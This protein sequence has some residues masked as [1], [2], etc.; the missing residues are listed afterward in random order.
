MK[1]LL[2]DLLS[3]KVKK[4]KRR[5]SSFGD[6]EEDNDGRLILYLL[7]N[8]DKD[9]FDVKYDRKAA[10]ETRKENMQAERSELKQILNEEFGWFKKDS[11][12]N[13][14]TAIKQDQEK[15][16]VEFEE[17]SKKS[18]KTEYP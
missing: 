18:K 14:D 2:S 15:F 4:S 8:G 17:D 9:D 3:R 12:I 1:L 6:V 5:D 10:K 13:T 11:V 16:K 7:M